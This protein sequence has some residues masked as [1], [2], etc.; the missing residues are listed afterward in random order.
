VGHR[1]GGTL[2]EVE[3]VDVTGDGVG[4]GRCLRIRLNLDITKPLDRGRALSLNGKSVRVNLKYEKLPQFCYTCGRI[5]HM[6]Q[7]CT[8]R[9]V[10][11]LREMLALQLPPNIHGSHTHMSGSCVE[12]G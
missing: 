6:G 4:W 5:L 3:D 9:K 8:G 2:G 10:F 1:I 12:I 11:L 7:K